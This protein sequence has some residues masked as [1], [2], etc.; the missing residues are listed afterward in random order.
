MIATKLCLDALVINPHDP[1]EAIFSYKQWILRYTSTPVA[2]L[3]ITDHPRMR[4]YEAFNTLFFA[5]VP[6]FVE[7]LVHLSEFSLV[8]R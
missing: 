7:R 3:E 6:E 4:T 2:Q 8:P 5:L 1:V